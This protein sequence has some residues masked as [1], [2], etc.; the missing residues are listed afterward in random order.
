[1]FFKEWPSAEGPFFFLWGGSKSFWR[2]ARSPLAVCLQDREVAAVDRMMKSIIHQQTSVL[3][4]IQK[5]GTVSVSVNVLSIIDCVGFC[6]RF[7]FTVFISNW[8]QAK[9]MW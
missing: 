5:G 4:K 6:F 9:N 3:C 8:R 1:M 7:F 2:A